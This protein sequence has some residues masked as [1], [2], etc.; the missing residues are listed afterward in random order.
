MRPKDPN[1]VPGLSTTFTLE[2]VECMSSMFKMLSRG[3]YDVSVIAR[4]RAI[5]TIAKKF[6]RLKEKAER[7]RNT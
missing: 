2:E 1:R 7:S 5:Y 4:N 6:D 3:T